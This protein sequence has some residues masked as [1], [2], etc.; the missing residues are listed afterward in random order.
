MDSSYPKT[1]H[2]IYYRTKDFVY[3]EE[4]IPQPFRIGQI[5]SFKVFLENNLRAD[6]IQQFLSNVGITIANAMSSLIGQENLVQY[7]A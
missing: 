5:L 7:Q 2:G 1:Q 6:Q 3:L 4:N